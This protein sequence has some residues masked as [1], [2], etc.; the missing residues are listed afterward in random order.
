[1]DRV[2]IEECLEKD[3]HII[4]NG[5]GDTKVVF[6][7]GN[8]KALACEL[9]GIKL[10]LLTKTLNEFYNK[11]VCARKSSKEHVS[12][13]NSSHTWGEAITNPKMLITPDNE[14]SP[15]A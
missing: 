2:T 11:A 8:V 3:M 9:E 15:A 10:S 13:F 5:K 14:K 6:A 7:D 4:Y 1:M 12:E